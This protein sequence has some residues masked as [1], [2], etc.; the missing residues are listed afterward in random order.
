MEKKPDC[1]LG[2][3]Y[4]ANM[5]ISEIF[6]KSPE[7]LAIAY[8]SPDTP[9]D[10]KKVIEHYIE[11]PAAPAVSAPSAPVEVEGTKQLTMPE[12]AAEPTKVEVNIE[13]PKKE[14][15][16][17]KPKEAPTE[18]ET[19]ELKP[20]C[21]LAKINA[22]RQAWS[23]SDIAKDGKGKAG[24][25]AKYDY[26]KPQQ[27]IDFCLVQ[28]LQHDIFSEFKI[29]D[30]VCSYVVVDIPSG[31]TRS[32]EC[33][34]DIPRKMAA[35]EAQQVG[36]AMTYHNRRLA[37]MMYK[38]ED[39]SKENIDVLENADFSAQNM[40]APIIPAPPIITPPPANVAPPIIEQATPP[41]APSVPVSVPNIPQGKIVVEEPEQIKTDELPAEKEQEIEAPVVEDQKA[42]AVTPPGGSVTPPS[43]PNESGL[44]NGHTPYMSPSDVMSGKTKDKIV[45]ENNNPSIPPPSK[46]QTAPPAQTVEVPKTSKN[47]IEA[48]YE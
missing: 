15:K 9:E 32:V 31:E 26:Y 28:E 20:T 23:K 30:G 29:N 21:L 18:T 27:V 3:G 24:G 14:R 13:K 46:V 38:I 4:N 19:V 43:I 7:Y 5:L 37:M 39:N 41:E 6:S 17:A 47:N 34:F 1:K 22:I 10:V 36:A 8:N 45:V 42:P 11:K 16:M 44:A 25:G 2:V 35:S 40:P 12:P 33:P 48:L